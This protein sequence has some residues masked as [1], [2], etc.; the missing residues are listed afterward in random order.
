MRQRLIGAVVLI[1]L[2]VIFVPMLLNG[3]VENTVIE[4]PLEIPIKPI[5]QKK[6]L[7]EIT[8]E[9]KFA[10]SIPDT[11]DV[12]PVT[13]YD[14]NTNRKLNPINQSEKISG[15]AEG[16]NKTAI[17]TVDNTS[18]EKVQSNSEKSNVKSINK[19][20]AAQV[21]SSVTVWDVQVGSFSSSKNALLLRDSLRKKGYRAFVESILVKKKE[22]FRV[23]IGP[24]QDKIK[25]QKIA[26]RL[27]KE[28][29]LPGKVY[30][31]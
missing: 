7:A 17:N 22:M 10:E 28:E 12:R 27:K 5:L 2:V 19:K 4:V 31:H 11:S 3:P 6:S 16:T 1:S 13:E 30:K 20:S 26:D 15:V 9:G 8:N 14:K 24:E 18:H 21:D 23:R 29:K 25:A